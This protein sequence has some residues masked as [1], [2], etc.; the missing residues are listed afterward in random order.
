MA[1]K[2]KRNFEETWHKNAI[3]YHIHG[4]YSNTGIEVKN[5]IEDIAITEGLR[6]IHAE[7]HPSYSP[8]KPVNDVYKSFDVNMMWNE[9]YQL[10]HM[11]SDGLNKILP[12]QFKKS[13]EPDTLS[14]ENSIGG[15]RV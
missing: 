15:S 7:K 3:F 8:D 1:A 6:L 13:D 4:S 2:I 5:I 14:D 10:F 12:G 9:L 11:K